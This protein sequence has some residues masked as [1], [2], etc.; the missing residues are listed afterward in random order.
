MSK[1]LTPD[2][3]YAIAALRGFQ[4]LGPEVTN[5]RT[6]TRWLCPK[7]HVFETRYSEIQKGSGCSICAHEQTGE[8]CR[9]KPERYHELAKQRGIEWIGD[10]PSESHQPTLWRCLQ[11]HEFKM[12]YGDIRGGHGC[13]YCSGLLPKT[14]ADYLTLA[15]KRGF[16]IIGSIPANVVSNAE[17]ECSFGHRWKAAYH[18]IRKGGGCPYCSNSVPKTAGDYAALAAQRGIFWIGPMPQR[19]EFL[20]EWQCH[21]GHRWFAKFS[22]VYHRASGC[23]ECSY[24]QRQS[25]RRL[26]PDAYYR[27]AEK[28]GFIWLG[29]HVTST[30]AKTTWQCRS[31]HAWEATYNNISNGTNCPYCIDYVNG[32]PVSK[33]QRHL[34]EMVNGELN[35]PVKRYRIDVALFIGEIKIAIEYDC[36]FWHSGLSDHENKRDAYLTKHGWRVLRVK[37]NIAL[38]TLE[39]L[40]YAISG[41]LFGEIYTEIVLDW[42]SQ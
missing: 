20:T 40:D 36:Q 3:Y 27:L 6:K 24:E 5:N 19:T 18:S 21:L 13:V 11:R 35:Y 30:N 26:K 37:A 34:C 10:Y 25:S 16:K 7:G 31:N 14:E 1:R 39:Q 8:R 15:Q 17:W 29:S 2:A 23:P 4:W 38:P 32:Q 42:K 9:H 22:N 41:L 28:R 12:S 33:P